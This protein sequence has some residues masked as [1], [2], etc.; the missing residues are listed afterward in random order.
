MHS[1]TVGLEGCVCQADEY[2]YNPAANV[3]Q[4]KSCPYDRTYCENIG[5]GVTLESLPLSPGFWRAQHR[6]EKIRGCHH[7]KFC[8]GGRS[9]A[10]GSLC[11]GYCAENHTG[12]YCELCANEYYKEPDGT[13]AKCEGS[14]VVWYVVPGLVALVLLFFCC[15]GNTPTIQ[16]NALHDMTGVLFAAEKKR[17]TTREI[18]HAGDISLFERI[19]EGVTVVAKDELRH[20]LEPMLR[21]QGLLWEDVE[22]LLEGRDTPAGISNEDLM[23]DLLG[24]LAAGGGQQARKLAIAHLRPRIELVLQWAGLSWED[25]VP[26][27]EEVDTVEELEHAIHDPMAFL[28]EMAKKGGTSA[29]KLSI[30]AMRQHLEPVL[31]SHIGMAWEDIKPVH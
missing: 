31:R 13:C 18:V 22:M 10:G 14:T 17:D 1:G 12:P 6:S 2:D 9:C 23:S 5:A 25:I 15:C 21:R 11:D 24:Q 30:A 8:A 19:G 28:E 20:R 4:C 3:T 7:A 26:V 29:L 27:L 16:T